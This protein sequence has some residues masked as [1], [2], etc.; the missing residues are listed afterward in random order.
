MR[1]LPP[2]IALALLCPAPARADSILYSG[3]D[4]ALALIAGLGYGNLLTQSMTLEGFSFFVTDTAP[5]DLIFKTAVV[6]ID[7]QTIRNVLYE[8]AWD[9]VQPDGLSHELRTLLP[10]SIAVDPLHTALF[11]IPQTSG[12]TI[13]AT[14]TNQYTGIVGNSWNTVNGTV[15]TDLP[16][17][18]DVAMRLTAVPEPSTWLLVAL[19]AWVVALRVKRPTA[20]RTPAGQDRGQAG[21]PGPRQ[22]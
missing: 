10:S 15:D 16:Q 17:D 20:A 4:G 1:L 6:T 5:D 19:G 14:A 7:G 18:R 13:Q 2:L 22:R 9:T 8:S 21:G 11:L 3:N 12:W